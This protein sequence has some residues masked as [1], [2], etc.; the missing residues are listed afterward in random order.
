M[1]AKNHKELIVFSKELV[2]TESLLEGLHCIS[3]NSGSIMKAERC[4]IFIYDEHK[5]ELWT[6][7]AD[8]AGKIIIPSDVG[9]V[10]D[11]LRLKKVILENEPYNNPNFLSD[12]DMGTGYYTQNLL[13]APIFNSK[14]HVV[15]VL[16]LLNKENG[17]SREDSEFITFFS[18]Y[19]SGFIE[20]HLFELAN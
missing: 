5:N 19:I 18:H 13:T 17:F 11:T 7:L 10:G 16:E 9:I 1:T 2:N 8:G 6:T 4:S 3:K 15:G 20:L 12:I 14:R